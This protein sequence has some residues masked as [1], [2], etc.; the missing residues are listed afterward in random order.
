MRGGSF[1]NLVLTAIDLLLTSVPPGL[2]LCLMLGTH[3]SFN[4]LKEDG[5]RCLNQRL[6]NLAGRVGHVCF[7][8]T[9]TL[10][11]SGVSFSGLEL[12]NGER[13]GT[14]LKF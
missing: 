5:I 11:D 2:G 1:V 13:K 14:G 4:N 6:I 3:F 9:G 10:T 7:D 12:V 8:K